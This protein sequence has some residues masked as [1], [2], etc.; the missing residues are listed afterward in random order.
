MSTQELAGSTALVTGASRGFGRGIAI[1]LA[2]AGASVVAVARGQA[3]LDDLRAQ[4]GGDVIPVVADAT[5]SG[6]R[7]PSDRRI[8]AT[9]ARAQRGGVAADA[10]AGHAHV[11]D[12]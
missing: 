8:Q 7:R 5:E 9:N 2:K 3:A 4:S 10:P 11:G 6:H 12:V 1:S